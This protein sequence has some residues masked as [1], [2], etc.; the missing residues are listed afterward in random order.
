MQVPCTQSLAKNDRG[1]AL[2]N[3]TANSQLVSC[4]DI[5]A[6]AVKMHMS[7]GRKAVSETIFSFISACS[8][9]SYA[10]PEW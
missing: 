9:V 6:Q 4:I 7:Q 5:V 2:R 3:A 1:R 10:M 8:V